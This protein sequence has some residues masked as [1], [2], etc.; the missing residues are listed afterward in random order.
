MRRVGQRQRR[1]KELRSPVASGGSRRSSMGWTAERVTAAATAVT[2]AAVIWSIYVD[3]QHQRVAQTERVVVQAERV[4]AWIEHEDTDSDPNTAEIVLYVTNSSDSPVFD[5]HPFAY[6][7]QQEMLHGP[8]G[9]INVLPPGETRRMPL[10][11]GQYEPRGGDFAIAT[12]VFQDSKGRVWWRDSRG[13]LKQIS[14]TPL[15]HPPGDSPVT[16]N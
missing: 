11:S 15:P 3:Q 16:G 8:P 6:I 13:A 2:A 12:L 4:S 5:V 9:D 14:E 1:L 7:P 10:G